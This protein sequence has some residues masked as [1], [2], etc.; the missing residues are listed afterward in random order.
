MNSDDFR[1]IDS[2]HDSFERLLERC[3]EEDGNYFS[4]FV[5]CS[6]VEELIR[7]FFLLGSGLLAAEYSDS[8]PRIQSLLSELVKNNTIFRWFPWHRLSNNHLSACA[9][10]FAQYSLGTVESLQ[11]PV[12]SPVLVCIRLLE[13]VSNVTLSDSDIATLIYVARLLRHSNSLS[14]SKRIE[15]VVAHAI[16]EDTNQPDLASIV[17][18]SWTNGN[19]F[20]LSRTRA[21]SAV[22]SGPDSNRVAALA[23]VC[24]AGELAA[25][26]VADAPSHAAALALVLCSSVHV[27]HRAAGLRI[28]R[29]LVSFGDIRHRDVCLECLRDSTVLPNSQLFLSALLCLR[30]VMLSTST[31]EKASLAKPNLLQISTLKFMFDASLRLAEHDNQGALAAALALPH[32]VHIGGEALLTHTQVFVD[33]FGSLFLRNA[34]G[35]LASR[36]TLETKGWA[37]Q[38]DE[39]LVRTYESPINSLVY[40]FEEASRV[41]WA[42]LGAHRKAI[43]QACVSAVLEAKNRDDV[44]SASSNVLRILLQCDGSDGSR[45]LMESLRDRSAQHNSLHSSW[46]LLDRV[47]RLDHEAVTKNEFPV[48]HRFGVLTNNFYINGT[49]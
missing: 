38:Y 5:S 8:V 39:P 34:R 18:E 27:T 25:F 43:I 46:K 17:A 7:S 14:L 12:T 23:A 11:L 35:S 4:T 16:G 28:V 49:G 45:K 10:H 26:H 22:D 40:A 44:M 6:E 15:F 31:V 42:R 47:L 48:R 13:K 36:L 2:V 21:L 32:T 33:I 30:D 20:S 19:L 1:L 9:V 24:A 3:E 37:F 29:A 41:I